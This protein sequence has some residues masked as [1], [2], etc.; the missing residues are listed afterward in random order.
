MNIAWEKTK[1]KEGVLVA[2][3]RAMQP[4]ILWWYNTLRKY[5]AKPVA[6]INLGGIC[7][8]VK[9]WCK[10]NGYYYDNEKFVAHFK[11]IKI[12]TKYTNKWAD[13]ISGDVALVRPYWFTKPIA[14][15]HTPFEKTLYLDIDCELK[16]PTDEI[17]SY[18]NGNE[19]ALCKDISEFTYFNSNK[20]QNKIL[21]NSGVIVYK[22]KSKIVE[23]WAK[24]SYEYNHDFLG[25]QDLLSHIIYKYKYKPKILP[26]HWNWHAITKENDEAKILHYTGGIAK[27]KLFENIKKD[28]SLIKEIEKLLNG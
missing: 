24:M 12:P 7:E 13:L 8:N 2:F 25:D 23:K 20:D 16:S 11:K 14:M 26:I 17:F 3:D 10:N 27:R 9:N 22:S 1:E 6:F 5:S 15:M 4:L 19:I 21:F 28:P 18:L